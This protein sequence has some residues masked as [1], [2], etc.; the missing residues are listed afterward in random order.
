MPQQMLSWYWLL[1]ARFERDLEANGKFYNP[2]PDDHPH[3]TIT[4]ICQFRHGQHK[5][6]EAKPMNQ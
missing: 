2:Q 5:I 4:Q 3:K 6:T 1:T